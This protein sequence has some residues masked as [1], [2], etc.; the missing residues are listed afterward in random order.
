MNRRGFLQSLLGTAASIPFVPSLVKVPLFSKE[1][2]ENISLLVEKHKIE[3][4]EN[5]DIYLHMARKY[6]A[7]NYNGSGEILYDIHTA[8]FYTK[9]NTDRGI[10]WNPMKQIY[11]RERI[12]VRDNY[13]YGIK[14]IGSEYYT[15]PDSYKDAVEVG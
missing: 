7:D 4:A 1:A 8:N 15:I 14:Y 13:A 3:V 12:R 2:K 10:V 11:D 9:K 6:F 5:P